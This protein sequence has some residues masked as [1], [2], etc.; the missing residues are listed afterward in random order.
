S[1]RWP[2]AALCGL[3]GTTLLT[4][5]LGF[6][7]AD[8]PAVKVVARADAVEEAADQSSREAVARARRGAHLDKV[9]VELWHK[10]GH[11]GTGVKVAILDT[12]F[13]GWKDHLGKSLPDKVTVKSFRHDANLEARDSQHGILCGEVVH[14]L[15]PDAELLFANWE[16]DEPD[17]F[18]EA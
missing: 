1:P 14:A 7:G 6:G 13:R 11:K 8:V 2:L 16:A 3:L 15:A 5:A 4:G 17:R 18:L 12:G 10:S 9:G